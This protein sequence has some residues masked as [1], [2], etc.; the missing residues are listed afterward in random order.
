MV[1]TSRKM[2]GETN[3]SDSLPGTI[4]GD[5]AVEVG[6]SVIMSA[7]YKTKRILNQVPQLELHYRSGQIWSVSIVFMVAIVTGQNLHSEIANKCIIVI[8]HYSYPYS[9]VYSL[10]QL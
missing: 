2:L 1:R 10:N 7:N 3:P 6:R 5:Y 8:L 4:R 9:T